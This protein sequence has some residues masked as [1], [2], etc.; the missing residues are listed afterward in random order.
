[1]IVKGF[2]EVGH[3][4]LVEMPFVLMRY[5]YDGGRRA[6]GLCG[7]APRLYVLVGSE[8]QDCVEAIPIAWA[9][10]QALAPETMERLA[11]QLRRLRGA[12]PPRGG[13]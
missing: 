13:D 1:M 2:G 10:A 9:A 6:D 4:L 7:A 11:L 8:E 5:D 12:E 3:R